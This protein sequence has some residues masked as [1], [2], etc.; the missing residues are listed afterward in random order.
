MPRLVHGKL[1]KT[2][3]P[4]I[5]ST[6]PIILTSLLACLLLYVLEQILAVSYLTK[7]LA[8]IILFAGLPGCYFFFNKTALTEGTSVK[9]RQEG[10][11]RSLKPGALF[12]IL[13]FCIVLAAYMLLQD[14]LD[15]P[16]IAQE[17]TEKSQVTPAN[18][19]LVG[20]YITIGNS[21]LE[22][23]FFRGFLFGSLSRLG[24]TQLAYVYSSLLFGLYH[25]AIF[26]TWFNPWMM[27][28]A[29]VGLV[30]VGFIFNWLNTKA[31]HFYNSWLAHVFADA[32]IILV[33]L[34]MFELI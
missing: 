28:L 20:F 32:A 31:N 8:K 18:F 27:S 2:D 34:R 10:I 22:E 13:A 21:F 15:L 7:T 30:G 17:L 33:G 26:Q 5:T 12:G 11:L 9:A 29:L 24:R 6:R 19:L 16:A 23:F 4:A 25:I 14:A 3:S 1:E